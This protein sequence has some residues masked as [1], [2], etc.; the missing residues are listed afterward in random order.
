MSTPKEDTRSGAI[1]AGSNQDVCRVGVR[2]PPF[3]PEEPAVWFAQIEGQ[4]ALSGINVDATKFYYV[5]SQLDHQYAAEVK[6]IIIS[7]PANDKYE[8]L[9]SELIKRLTSSKESKIKQLLM[10]EELGDRKPSQFLRHLQSLSGTTVSDDL[11]RTIW[12]SR[13]PNNLQTIIALQ[14]DSPLEA[15]ADLVDHVHDIA[16]PSAAQV[17]M[18]SAAPSGIN[19]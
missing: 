18:T 15:V 10:H 13:L 17:A 12:S 6:D 3:W 14:K 1:A 2:V 11:M 16:P 7:P 4:F 9:K 19:A 8:K 5:V